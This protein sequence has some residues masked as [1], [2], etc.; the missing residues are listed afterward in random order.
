[1]GGRRVCP[2]VVDPWVVDPWVVD[3]WVVDPWASGRG[4][5]PA[6]AGKIIESSSIKQTIIRNSFF[7]NMIVSFKPCC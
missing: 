4:K 7:I 6:W 2:W 1:M 3:P 5:L